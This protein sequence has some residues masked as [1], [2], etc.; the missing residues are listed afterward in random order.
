MED[1][2]VVVE[3]L[4]VLSQREVEVVGE[5]VVEVVEVASVGVVSVAVVAEVGCVVGLAGA[6]V[7]VPVVG[8]LF[9]G[10]VVLVWGGYPW[11]LGE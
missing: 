7:W 4:S 8:V 5:E 2:V 11:N 6:V 3:G 10:V 1:A 9:V